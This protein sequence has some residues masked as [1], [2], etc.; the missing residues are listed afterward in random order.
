V[1]KR[2]SKSKVSQYAT[3]YKIKAIKRVERGEGA[4]P[5]TRGLGYDSG[6]IA[7]STQPKNQ[8]AAGCHKVHRQLN[9]NTLCAHEAIQKPD[10]C[11][12]L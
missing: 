11:N 5:V 8:S 1:L 6:T 4:L 9:C 7:R 10:A 3:A 2:S 12:V